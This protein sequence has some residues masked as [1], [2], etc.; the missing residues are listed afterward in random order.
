M[1]TKNLVPRNSGEG[2]VGKISKPWE[3]GVFDNLYIKGVEFTADQS[4][5]TGDNVEFNSGNFIN[6]LTVGGID[7]ATSVDSIQQTLEESSPFIFFS[8][9][10][11]NIGVTDKTFYE[12][13]PNS[14]TH[15]SGVVVAKAEDI[16]AYIQWDGPNDEYIGQASINGQQIPLSNIS[17]LGT[18]TRRFEGYL[19][20]LNLIGETGITGEANGR[21]VVLPISELGGG[22]TP[23]NILIDSISNST[24]KPGEEK[25]LSH[26]K[27]GDSI[28]IYIDFPTNDVDLIKIHDYGIAKEIDFTNYSLQNVNGFYRA[29]IPIEVSSREGSLSVAV[30]AINSFGTTGELKE[31]S[32][33]DHAS[34]T[35]DVDQTYPTINASNPTSYNG[36]SDG[37][38]EGESTSFSNTI[39]NWINNTDTVSY[40]PLSNDISINNQ[41]TYSS[42]KTVNYQGG[43]YNNSDNLEI[44][45]VR[46][47]NGATDR[48]RVNIKIAN[49]PVI[50]STE[51]D[52]LASSASSPHIVGT[53]EVKAGDVLNAKI[54]VDGKG[55]SIN[56][57]SISLSNSGISDGSQTSYSSNYSKTTLLNGNYE[58][59][60]PIN[61]YGTLGYSTRDGD[62]SATFTARN[63]FGTLSD[64]VTTTDTSKILNG[65][66]PSI[67]IA[68]VIYPNNQ[69]AIKQGE[70]LYIENT[71]T[72]YDEITYSST[73][74]QLSVADNLP[75]SYNEFKSF[76]YSSGTYN[77]DGD[78][79]VNNIKIV[80]QKNSNGIVVEEYVIGNIANSPLELTI[81]NLSS[82]LKS[83]STGEGYSFSLQSNQLMLSPPTLSVDSSQ[84]SPSSLSINSSGTGKTNNSFNLTVSDADTKGTFN[85]EVSAT[86]LAG[87][88]TTSVTTNPTYTLEGF[89]SRTIIAS[90]NSLGAG[91]APVGTSV[92]DP[93]NVL[94]ENVSEGGTAANGGTIY[95]YQ[96]YS[97]GIQLDNS[98]DL[99]NKFTVCDSNGITDSNGD[100]V[101]NLDK[102]NRSANSSTANPATFI[103]SE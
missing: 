31:S 7:V 4:L 36:R 58:F 61:V 34:G 55:V 88:E 28:N 17:Q 37:L 62:Q 22:P 46:V 45:A 41:N 18:D 65:I 72:N 3:S 80:A 54:E 48:K 25:G 94:F 85:W 40:T 96:N 51:M 60:I 101:F 100:H 30:Q 35:R 6:G 11:D 52:S 91:L 76:S 99:N 33:F 97:D 38:R 27:E 39:S 32:D 53:T 12:N 77:V 70:F 42:L 95:T 102:L 21:S 10:L 50:V 84:T 8:D 14:E 19:D 86:N 81:L 2:S 20:N 47:G 13:T 15:L 82:S 59:S 93:N 29:T 56:D 87:I 9:V 89:N 68:R 67:T 90:P 1:A 49:G 79:G 74:S 98:Y 71:I 69:E 103:V 26:L 78:G 66:I 63:N 16:K 64:A 83:S 43:I 24:A 75:N 92:S 73:N 57:I 23:N 5:E 44:Y